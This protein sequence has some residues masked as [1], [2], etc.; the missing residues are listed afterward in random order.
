MTSE[1][2]YTGKPV[3]VGITGASG[4]VLGFRLIKELLRISQPVELVMTEKSLQVILEET[5]LKIGGGSG[6]DKIDKVI[7]YLQAPSESR[8][9]L[10][11]YGNHRLDAPPSSGTHLTRGMAIIPCSMGTLGRVATGI[12]DNLVARAADVTMK[13]HR[14]LIIV[15]RESPLNQIHLKNLLTLSQC[16]VCVIPPVLSFYLMDFNS[17]EGQINYTVGKVLDQLGFEH[18]LYTRWG[19]QN[20]SAA[21]HKRPADAGPVISHTY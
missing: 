3:V 18:D 7:Q 12:T 20:D 1:L 21:A 11:V 8:H 5:G 15:P 6:E 13:E 9:L 10:K 17:L 14:K 2:S 19:A 16:G 4:S